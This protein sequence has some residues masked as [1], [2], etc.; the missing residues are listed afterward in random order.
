LGFKLIT[1]AS[2]FLQTVIC[3]RANPKCPQDGAYHSQTQHFSHD[4]LVAWR[5][6]S[7]EMPV[8][9]G[10]TQQ[11]AFDEMGKV[12][13]AAIVLAALF[14]LWPATPLETRGLP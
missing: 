1:I 13:K 11:Q 4:A 2:A 5:D 12:N 3:A 10:A 8:A 6:N 9:A 14:F 7:L